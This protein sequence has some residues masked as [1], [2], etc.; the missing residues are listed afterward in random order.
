[1]HAAAEIDQAARPLDLCRKDVRRKRVHRESSRVTFGSRA[2]VRYAVDAR[3]MDHRVHSTNPVDLFRN[4][5]CLGS[6][7]Q[8]ADH[9][10]SGLRG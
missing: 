1:M 3:V 9:N 6:T 4:L 10:P 7:A 5:V 8:I 2:P